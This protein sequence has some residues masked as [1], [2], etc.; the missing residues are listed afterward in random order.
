MTL[1][2]VILKREKKKHILLVTPINRKRRVPSRAFPLCAVSG[3]KKKNE[4]NVLGWRMCAKGKA[5]KKKTK[6]NKKYFSG[7]G[8]DI[9]LHT[10]GPFV[11]PPETLWQSTE[12]EGAGTASPHS[13]KAGK[14]VRCLWNVKPLPKG[15]KRHLYLAF[16]VELPQLKRS[17]K[18]KRYFLTGEFGD[19]LRNTRGVKRGESKQ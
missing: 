3:F 4:S 6:K 18:E 13:E 15:E 8:L 12:G 11:V 7:S 19:Y 17:E 16:L 5:K 2:S 10:G 9:K 14:M 1:C